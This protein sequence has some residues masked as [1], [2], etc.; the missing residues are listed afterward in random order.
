MTETAYEQRVGRVEQEQARQGE[1]MERIEGDVGRVAAVAT[2]NSNKLDRLLER[3]ASRPASMTPQ[4]VAYA[5]CGIASVGAVVWWLIGASP[6][7][8]DLDRR[9]SKLDDPEV[10]RV[11]RIEKEL[12]WTAAQKQREIE[13]YEQL[14]QKM[15]AALAP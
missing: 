4:S 14:L 3:D 10:G 5:C 13:G 9:I 15:E 6:A 7:V 12:G 2:V 8:Q 1:R 11:T